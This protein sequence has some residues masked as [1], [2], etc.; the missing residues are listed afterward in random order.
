MAISPD[1]FSFVELIVSLLH[2]F[3]FIVIWHVIYEGESLQSME[4]SYLS[5]C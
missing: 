3:S 5:G 1:I 4:K 2:R